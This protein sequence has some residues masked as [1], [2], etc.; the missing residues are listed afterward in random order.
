MTRVLMLVINP[1]TADARV[2]KEAASLAAT[3][4]EVTILATAAE[5]VPAREE[6]DG[7]TILRLPYQRVVKDRITGSIERER[8]RGTISGRLRA[9]VWW[10]AGGSYLKIMR[11]RLLPIEYF[12]GLA[13]EALDLV[14]LPAVIHAHDLGTLRAAVKL[15]KAWKRRTGSRPRVVYDSHELYVEQQTRWPWWEKAMWKAHERRWIHHAD[16]VIAVSGGIADQLQRRYRLSTR[17]HVILNSPRA[18]TDRRLGRDVRN[19]LGLEPRT[20]LAV[21]AGAVKPSRGVDELVDAMSLLPGWHLAL[22][23]TTPES[24]EAVLG[25]RSFPDDLAARVHT[26]RP[27]PYW[28]LPEYLSSATVGV[29]PLPDSCLNHRLA[30][31]NKLFDYLFAGLPVVVNDLPEMGNLVRTRAVGSTYEGGEPSS[32][33]RAL[34]GSKDLLV[35][36]GAIDDLSWDRQEKL[37]RALYDILL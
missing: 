34:E 30:L 29:H 26:L 14:T 5:G 18:E 37:L 33:A 21:Y 8:A 4:C 25:S 15:A 2:E 28:S 1:M 16:A 24:L 9:R 22:V 35:S 12:R 11:S 19:D 23:G 10:L 3:G 32:L 17:P 7:F 6:R 27:V 31:P 36:P 13:R 20:L